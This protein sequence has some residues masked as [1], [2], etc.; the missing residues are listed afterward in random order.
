MFDKISEIIKS[1]L[2]DSDLPTKEYIERIII[3]FL[4]AIL[5]SVLL[6]M[7]INNT[8]LAERMGL[9]KVEKTLPL[10]SHVDLLRD[11]QTTRQVIKQFSDTYT[12]VKSSFIIVLVDEAGN[13]ITK[14]SQTSESN[15][16][17]WTITTFK[18]GEDNLYILEEAIRK[19]NKI[20][21]KAFVFSGGCTSDK[22][23]G[24]DLEKN[25]A[26]SDMTTTH[27]V[28]CPLFS[29]KKVMLGYTLSFLS[30]PAVP[31]NKISTKGDGNTVLLWAFEDRLLIVTKVTESYL[32]GF[33][34]EYK[35]FYR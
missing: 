29:K 17:M 34:T 6:Y 2:P 18:G 21:L 22:I 30:L 23:R 24:T 1:L 4:L 19:F 27:Y 15:T 5:V 9:S 31:V 32:N 33:E 16:L 14:S 20:I 12:E 25:R 28:A 13:I 8:I 3:N 11:I 10:L 7:T 35:F 26:L